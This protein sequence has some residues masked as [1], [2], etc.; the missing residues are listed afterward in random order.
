MCVL[1]V[2]LIPACPDLEDC[3]KPSLCVLELPVGMEPVVEC[4]SCNVLFENGT[5]ATECPPT[6]IYLFNVTN[7]KCGE[8]SQPF[9][10]QGDGL[11]IA[12]ECT[13]ICSDGEW[14]SVVQCKCE[15]N[16]MLC[17]TYL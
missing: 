6:D 9:V 10:P 17:Y 5:C 3:Q 12:A 4:S 16:Q 8:S 11:V 1:C 13:L 2:C 14:L 15:G 7:R